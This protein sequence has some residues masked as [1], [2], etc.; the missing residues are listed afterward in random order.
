[1]IDHDFTMPPEWA[2]QEGVLLSAPLNPCTWERNRTAMEQAYARFGAAI[3]KQEKLFFQCEKNAQAHWQKNFEL[4]GADLQQIRWLDVRTNDAWCR[5]HGPIILKDP[6]GKRAVCN[7]KYNAWGGKFPPWDLDD[8]VPEKFA[9][10]F[11]MDCIHV[12]FVCEG[13]ALET[14]GHGVLM[15]T[16]SV[17]LNNNRNPGITKEQAEEILC[18]ALG[19]KEILWLPAGMP[20]DDTDGHID[21]LARFTEDGRIL[22]VSSL[23]RNLE[24]LQKTGRDVIL[25]PEPEPIH[26]ENWREEVLPATYA[27]YLIIN[28]AI[29]MPSYG[30]PEND[31]K[32]A[33][34]IG[35]AFPGR[36]IIPID[37]TD[38][39]LEGGA[40]HCLSQQIPL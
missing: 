25:L 39:L 19:M 3:S 24:I 4:A 26:P 15:T 7:F 12:P 6:T 16:E 8:A 11:R 17:I 35:S 33:E 20:G 34:I 1:M 37:C 38:I 13:G 28:N 21:T 10:M 5:D 29:L 18:N 9:A 22:A 31:R 23:P 36:T 32:A 2:E 30:Q 40:L 14:D 27:N